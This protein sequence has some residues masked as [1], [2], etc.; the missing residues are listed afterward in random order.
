MNSPIPHPNVRQTPSRVDARD[1]RA[2]A[3]QDDEDYAQESHDE[4]VKRIAKERY[5]ARLANLQPVDMVAGLHSAVT[6]V[7]GCDLLAGMRAGDAELGHTVRQLVLKAL[8]DDTE[9]EAE[10]IAS[11][12]FAKSRPMRTRLWDES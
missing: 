7:D 1:D 3:A 5:G 12:G 6:S 10:E 11:F 9:L 4:L 2:L 8:R